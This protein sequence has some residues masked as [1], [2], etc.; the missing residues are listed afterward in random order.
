V[1]RRNP[2]GATLTEPAWVGEGGVI[3]LTQFSFGSSTINRYKLAAITTFTR[4]LAERAV[5]AIEGLMRSALSEAY[6]QVLDAALLSSSA[7]VAGIR[8]AG[9]RQ[10]ITTAAG[11]ATGGN[12]SVIIDVKAMMNFFQTNRTGSRPVLIMNNATRLALSMQQSSLAEF[13]WRDEVA[14]GRLLGMEIVSSQNVPAGVV[15][16]IDA[17]SLALALD[18]PT[19]DVSDVATVTEANADTT[20]PTQ[21]NSGAAGAVGTGGQVAADGGIMVSGTTG[22]GA[23]GYTARSLWQTYS[24]GIRMVAPTSWAML[25]PNSAVERTGVTW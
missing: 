6:S 17:D 4:E 20:A 25:R 9:L 13:L 8:P 18:G 5:P 19:F 11:D 16:A 7:A 24:V 23:T 14:A 1:P 12:A 3:P 2:L 21:A 15:I 22:A 10:G